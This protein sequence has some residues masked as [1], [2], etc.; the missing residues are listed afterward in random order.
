M[1]TPKS[2]ESMTKPFKNRVG[3]NVKQVEII[4]KA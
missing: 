3:E 2:K 1:V 4:R